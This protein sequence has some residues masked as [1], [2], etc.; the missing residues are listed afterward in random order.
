M[1]KQSKQAVAVKTQVKAGA[2]ISNHNQGSR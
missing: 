2:L 1:N